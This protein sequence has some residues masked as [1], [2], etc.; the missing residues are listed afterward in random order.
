MRQTHKAKII[1]ISGDTAT[2]EYTDKSGFV[3]IC[4]R[5][6]SG[7]K[8]S[9]GDTVWITIDGGEVVSVVKRRGVLSTPFGIKLASLLF[10]VVVLLVL[11][12]VFRVIKWI[13]ITL[14]WVLV[15]LF[16][17]IWLFARFKRR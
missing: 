11:W 1:S 9:V 3:Q 7:I 14:V 17:G 6:P 10:M 15:L 5:L 4:S 8:V 13:L 12:L 16:V 2:Y